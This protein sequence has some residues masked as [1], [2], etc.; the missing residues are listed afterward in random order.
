MSAAV[1]QGTYA[2]LKFIKSRKVAQVMIEI[3]IEAGAQ[4]VDAFG[5]PNPA[6]EVPVAIARL[7]AGS[8]DRAANDPTKEKKAWHELP[9]AQQAAIRCNEP[10][11]RK[12]L[13][14]EKGAGTD[15]AEY[16]RRI[17]RVTSR[18]DILWGTYAAQ[19]WSDL[20]KEFLKWMG[21]A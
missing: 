16:V 9:A 4:F 3:P 17:C 20:D 7:V 6:A 12:F 19:I 5:T 2:D 18:A 1:I 8:G 15:P 11:F 14:E 21:R 10:A 13:A